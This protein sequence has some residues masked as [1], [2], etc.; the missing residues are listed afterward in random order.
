LINYPSDAC[1]NIELKSPVTQDMAVG[2]GKAAARA[3]R[4]EVTLNG[5]EP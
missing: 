4:R 3:F 5:V 2:I 1:V